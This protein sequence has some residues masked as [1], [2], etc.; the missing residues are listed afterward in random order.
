MS[1]SNPILTIMRSAVKKTVQVR[2]HRSAKEL[3]LPAQFTPKGANNEHRN[4]T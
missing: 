4:P 1:A 2:V 3:S